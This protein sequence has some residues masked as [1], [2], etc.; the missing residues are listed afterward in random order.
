MNNKI[1]KSL[2]GA[3]CLSLAVIG[4]A[5][6][7]GFSRGSADTDI[8]YE[9]GDFNMRTGM[10]F[11]SPDRT[12]S[13]NPNN[14]TLEGKNFA[15]SYVV[16][17]GAIKMNL[18]ETLR[19][20]GTFVNAFGGDVKYDSPK[21]LFTPSPTGSPG[22][23]NAG[24]L[25]EEFTVYES[26]LTCAVKFEV[27]KGNLYVLGG[28]FVENFD[29]FRTNIL[30]AGGIPGVPNGTPIGKA[31]LELEGNDV[32]F[33]VGAAYEIPEIAFRTELM[34]RSGTSYGAD[35]T[36]TIASPAGVN[37]L[38]AIGEGELP[39][40]VE[41]SVQSGVAPGWLAFGSVKWTDWSVTEQL[42]SRSFTPGGPGPGDENDYFWDDGWTV[43][44]GIG[45]A[46]NERVSGLAAI[47]WDQGVG[48]GWDHTSDSWTL[49]LGGSFK[50]T[51]GGELRAGGGI[52]HLSGAC[53]TQY[54][55]QN[56]CVDDGWAYAFN[57]GYAVKW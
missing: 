31:D 1:L 18:T 43:T 5:N 42:I 35:G 12:Y 3:T 47:T 11:V 36:L 17:S 6:A 21:N 45:H 32:G 53:E 26:A 34:Y 14:P 52:S 39:Q 38:P 40:S 44:A 16:P 24:K 55:A 7:G 48:T 51:I 25:N 20:A 37:V 22:V 33:R 30:I 23:L 54:G 29:Y 19:C 8:L 9:P 49:S 10:T 2:L 28:G 13:K 57:L 4:S 56:T 46:F 41:L 15:E 50:D 27:G